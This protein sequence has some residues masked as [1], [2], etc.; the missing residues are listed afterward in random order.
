MSKEKNIIENHWEGP[1]KKE[2]RVLGVGLLIWVGFFVSIGVI[3]QAGFPMDFVGVRILYVVGSLLGCVLCIIIPAIL[4]MIGVS[5]YEKRTDAWLPKD[6]YL[7]AVFFSLV[8]LYLFFELPVSI[9]DS[10]EGIYMT[11]M[12]GSYVMGTLLSFIW[13]FWFQEIAYYKEVTAK[14]AKGA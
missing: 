12:Y 8:W 5:N 10:N 1:D 14:K 3:V 9:L 11:H 13:T 6:Q 7:V 4:Q 2:W